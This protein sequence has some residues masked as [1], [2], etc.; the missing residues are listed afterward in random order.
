MFEAMF[1]GSTDQLVAFLQPML[2]RADADD[3]KLM[4][5]LLREAKHE[6][7][8]EHVGFVIDLLERC[9]TIDFDL[10]QEISRQL[11]A[12]AVSGMRSGVAGEPMPRDLADKKAA[13]DILAGLSRLSPA[14]EL[15]DHIRKSAISNIERSRFED[16]ELDE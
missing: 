3:L 4:G 10:H 11:F 8:F 2:P 14:Y 6:F 16:E 7:V 5:R 1:L 12:A 15:F 13:E 9:Q